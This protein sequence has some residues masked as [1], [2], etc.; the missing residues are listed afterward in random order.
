MS[1]RDL[2]DK[3]EVEVAEAKLKVETTYCE[4]VEAGKEAT[5]ALEGEYLEA[6]DGL[7][8]K[9]A[10]LRALQKKADSF[11]RKF[12]K[13]AIITGLIVLAILAAGYV[14]GFFAV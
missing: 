2:R 9:M 3:L 12:G 10:I 11:I 13:K 6:L 14:S 5:A 1:I 4:L 8:A 7:N